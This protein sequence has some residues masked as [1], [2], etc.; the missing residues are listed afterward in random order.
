[1]ASLITFVKSIDI[2]SGIQLMDARSKVVCVTC[3][4]DSPSLKWLPAGFGELGCE[5][6]AATQQ[7]ELSPA[8]TGVTFRET[9]LLPNPVHRLPASLGATSFSRRRPSAPA[10]SERGR[11]RASVTER[12]QAPN[13]SSSSL[14]QLGGGRTPCQREYLCSKSSALR[15]ARDKLLPWAVCIPIWRSFST[16]YFAFVFCPRRIS[17][18]F[19]P[20]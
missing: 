18:A 17:D 13:T 16:T 8:V 15:H 1:M 4:T 7:V 11:R 5:E 3:V 12:S 19:G 10:S 20:G 2:R 14:A 9:I 6:K